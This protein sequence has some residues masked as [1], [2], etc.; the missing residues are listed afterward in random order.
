[1]KL[2][3]Y[4]RQNRS[5]RV[6]LIIHTFSGGLIE[7]ICTTIAAYKAKANLNGQVHTFSALKGHERSRLTSGM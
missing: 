2:L 5:Q 4:K 6:I 7:A 3:V 1:M